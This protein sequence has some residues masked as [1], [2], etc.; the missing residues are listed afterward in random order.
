MDKKALQSK[1]F[2]AFF[3]SLAVMA[4]ILIV[5]LVTQTFGIAMSAFMSLGMAAIAVMC[6]SYVNKQGTLDRYIS[7]AKIVGDIGEKVDD[8]EDME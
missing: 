4:G 1:K 2:I 7:L 6:I 8:K 3:V 5:A